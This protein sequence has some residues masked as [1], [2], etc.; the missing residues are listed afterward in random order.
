[1][2][3]RGNFI[4]LLIVHLKGVFNGFNIYFLEKVNDSDLEGLKIT[5]HIDAHISSLEWSVF[6]LM[7][8]TRG[9]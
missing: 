9:S 7:A 5:G 8:E 6:N 2:F 3:V 1:M 4:N